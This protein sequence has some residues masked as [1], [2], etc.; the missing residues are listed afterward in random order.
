M[1]EFPG[2]G[3]QCNFGDCRLLDFLPI[4]CDACKKDFCASHYSYDAHCCQSSY[5]KDVQ[6]PVCPLCSKPIPVARG[7]RPDKPVSDHIDSNCKS[8]PALALKGK[9][10]TYNCSQRNCRKRELNRIDCRLAALHRSNRRYKDESVKREPSNSSSAVQQHTEDEALAQ[11][12]QNLLNNSDDYMT[13]EERDK[14]IA[15]E[16]QRKEYQQQLQ[17]VPA[18]SNHERCTIS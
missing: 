5:K 16:L 15:E 18:N 11:A 8:N 6:V 4:R 17:R 2:F 1:A 13:M 3:R 10:Y 7:E 14:A 9:I 12:L